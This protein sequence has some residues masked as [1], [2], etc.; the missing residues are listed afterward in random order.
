MKYNECVMCCFVDCY[1]HIHEV[2]VNASEHSEVAHNE[3]A[4]SLSLQLC[5]MPLRVFSHHVSEIHYES[6]HETHLLKVKTFTISHLQG[7]A[8]NLRL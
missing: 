7:L 6:L 8:T 2:G 4:V 3:H 1:L 5:D